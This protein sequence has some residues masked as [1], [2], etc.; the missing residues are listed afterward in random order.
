MIFIFRAVNPTPAL[1]LATKWRSTETHDTED[2]HT[3]CSGAMLKAPR[4]MAHPHMSQAWRR[5]RIKQ[6][7]QGIVSIMSWQ[8][9]GKR[10]ALEKGKRERK[11]IDRVVISAQ[12]KPMAKF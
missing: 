5:G 3:D 2:N 9:E 7:D 10:H 4:I 8:R 1:R 12:T 11:C 6:I